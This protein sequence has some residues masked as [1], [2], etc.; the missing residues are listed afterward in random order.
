VGVGLAGMRERM[1]QLG[2]WF[3]IESSGVGTSVR[4]IAPGEA[5]RGEDHE[6]SDSR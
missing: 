4:A 5:G 3:E 1:R 6:H 2:G